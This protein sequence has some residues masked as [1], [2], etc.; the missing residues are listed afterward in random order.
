MKIWAQTSHISGVR[1][2]AQGADGRHDPLVSK[3]A[4][5][6]KARDRGESTAPQSFGA[7]L[8]EVRNG[9]Q[10]DVKGLRR[11]YLRK[12]ETGTGEALSVLGG[13]DVEGVKGSAANDTVFVVA[14]RKVFRHVTE[15][16]DS[17]F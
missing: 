15:K 3:Q 6:A 13:A 2:R 4:D 17:Y 10:G 11:L 9:A 1:V 16:S 7:A 5:V 14:A 8:G 12:E